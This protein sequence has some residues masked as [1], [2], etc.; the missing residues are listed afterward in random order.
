LI[1]AL[2]WFHAAVLVGLLAWPTI[3]AEPLAAHR[4]DA[5]SLTGKVLC[6]YQGWFNCD[7]DGAGLGWTHWARD[8]RRPLAPGNATVDL[9]PDVT[10]LSDAE[11]YPTGFRHA[12]G[13][14]AHVFSS[15]NRQTVLRHCRWM[16]DHGIDGVF[17]QRFAGGLDQ[18]RL[19]RHKDHVLESIRLGTGQHGRVYAVMYDLSGLRAGE[20]A[21]VADD[22]RTLAEQKRITADAGYLHHRGKPVVAVWGIGFNDDRNYSLAECGDLVGQLKATGCTVMVGVPSWWRDGTR[23]AVSDP[24]LLQVIEAA[25]IV[26]PWT[27]GRYRTPEE[28]TRHGQQVWAADLA[29]CRAKGRTFLPVVFPGFSWHNLHGGPLNQIPRLQGGFLWSQITTAQQLGCEMVY[30]A[31][32]DEVDEGTAVFKCTSQPPQGDGTQFL[33]HEGLPSDFYLQLLGRAGKVLRGDR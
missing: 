13:S 24:L 9:W 16:H 6:G 8:A 25:D 15:A 17:L 31:M 22:W 30:V 28:A 4:V 10:E 12:D 19:Q 1:P 21:R 26:S 27:V 20:V 23:D 29:W 7:G 2:R 32:F 33:D 14:I 18:D 11:R 5:S 3:A